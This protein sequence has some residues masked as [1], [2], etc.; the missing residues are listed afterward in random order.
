VVESVWLP[1]LGLALCSVGFGSITTFIVLLFTQHGWVQAWLSLSAVSITFVLGRLI[2]GHLPDKTGGAKIALI[3]ILI[4][5]AGQACIWL[6]PS[7]LIVLIGA[8]L[9]GLGYSLVYPSFG[10]E[11]VRRTAPE[12]LGLA[13]GAY[14]AFLD[15][16]LGLANPVLGF[17][18]E[19]MGLNAVYMVSTNVVLFA[20]VIA[21]RL[22]K[23]P[24]GT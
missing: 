12:N 23:Q 11:A 2:L 3:C 24:S 10:V 14:T 18:A 1:G 4:E 6:A 21:L 7:S 20:T 5:A 13:T 8:S 16:S 22:L 19:A 17:L 9:T 15:L